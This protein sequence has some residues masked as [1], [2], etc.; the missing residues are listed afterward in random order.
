MQSDIEKSVVIPGYSSFLI[1]E[2]K[3]DLNALAHPTMPD[4][5]PFN[6]SFQPY[7]WFLYDFGTKNERQWK[8]KVD[9]CR[10]WIQEVSE[11]PKNAIK[12]MDLGE[13]NTFT[14][15]VTPVDT[16]KKFEMYC[17]FLSSSFLSGR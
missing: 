7:T 12:Y 6:K 5:V 14:F 11:L 3:D 16:G 13:V 15:R 10:Y 2:I 4:K 1:I 9:D 8:I 17:L